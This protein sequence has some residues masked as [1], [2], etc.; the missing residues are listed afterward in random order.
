MG[1]KHFK[2][3]IQYGGSQKIAELEP[4]T[5]IGKFHK[6]LTFIIIIFL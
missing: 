4:L 5:Y 6:V 1:K 3:L 2:Y